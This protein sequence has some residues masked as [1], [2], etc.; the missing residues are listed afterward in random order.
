V[1]DFFVFSIGDREPAKK[2]DAIYR[3]DG[4]FAFP[5]NLIAVD[6]LKKKIANQIFKKMR[7]APFFLVAAIIGGAAAQPQ[8]EPHDPAADPAAVVLSG[9][10]SARFTVLAPGLVRCERAPFSD[11][12][13][14]AVV[15]RRT[16]VPRF[17]VAR[18][19][20]GGVTISTD[21]AV[22]TYNPGW[23]GEGGDV[24]VLLFFFF[25]LLFF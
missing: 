2:I 11:A 5:K 10:G 16:A 21:V 18:G 13:T 8:L 4:T 3:V 7:I 1:N 23:V 19:E 9:D 20:G 25:S 6:F 12:A 17:E 22:V 14:V 24:D 15:N